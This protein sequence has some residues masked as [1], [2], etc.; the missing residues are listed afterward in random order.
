MTEPS[1][2]FA[3]NLTDDPEVRYPKG[4]LVLVED[5]VASGYRDPSYPQSGRGVTVRRP[6]AAFVLLQAAGRGPGCPEGAPRMP[7]DLVCRFPSA[8]A[9]STLSSIGWP[10]TVGERT[11]SSGPSRRPASPT[12]WSASRS[13]TTTRASPAAGGSS[14]SSCSRPRPPSDRANAAPYASSRA[15]TSRAVPASVTRVLT[16]RARAAPTIALAL[17]APT[18]IPTTCGIRRIRSGVMASSRGSSG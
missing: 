4:M 1:V 16:S 9:I 18:E 12:T 14:P 8:P 17:S 7:K 15:A 13:A 6:A 3:G 11:R 5:R 2:S 10:R